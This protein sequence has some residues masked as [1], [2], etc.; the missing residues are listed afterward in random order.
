MVGTIAVVA[1][2][3]DGYFPVGVAAEREE[4]AEFGTVRID[5]LDDTRWSM[6]RVQ[7]R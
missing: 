6:S 3:E 7:S 1:A 4:A 2:R 5:H